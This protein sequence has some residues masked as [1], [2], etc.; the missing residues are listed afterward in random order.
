MVTLLMIAITLV[1]HDVVTLGLKAI[2]TSRLTVDS[3]DPRARRHVSGVDGAA[4]QQRLARG[5]RQQAGQHLH[6]RG[7]A[8][9]VRAEKPKDL[10]AL[11][12]EA[13]PVHGGEV[14]EAAGEVVRHDHRRLIKDTARRDLDRLVSGPLPRWQQRDER[15]LH[16]G[17]A[18]HLLQLRRRSGRQHLPGVHRH[19]PVEPLGLLHVGGGDQDTHALA[20]RPHDI[21]EFPELPAR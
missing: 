19:Q 17:G 6:G 9:S 14:A 11:D 1:N 10:T 3:G 18:G 13:H 21:D 5:R 2:C 15:F 7:L 16:R 4:E 12:G 20:T 8:A